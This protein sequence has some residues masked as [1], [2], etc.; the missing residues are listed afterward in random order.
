MDVQI[1]AQGIE[2]EQDARRL[3]GIYDAG[4]GYFFG[5]PEPV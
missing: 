1:V 5:K 3:V 4:Q 2:S